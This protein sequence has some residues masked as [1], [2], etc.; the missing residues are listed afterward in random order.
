[1]AAKTGLAAAILA[2]ESSNVIYPAAM[3]HVSGSLVDEGDAYLALTSKLMYENRHI[4]LP[5]EIDP[6]KQNVKA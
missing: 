6:L 5:E 2:L 4:L 3:K 1:M